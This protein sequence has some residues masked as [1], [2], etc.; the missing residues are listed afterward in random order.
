MDRRDFLKKSGAVVAGG[1]LADLGIFEQAAGEAR[2]PKGRPNIV[3]ILVDEM[4]FPRVFPAGVDT[5]AEFLRRY[6][7]N[8]FYLWQHGG[9]VRG[10]LQFRQR[11]QPGAS[12]DRDRPVP[13]QQ[14]L[15]ATR[16][17]SGPSL[18]PGLPT[19]GKLLRDSSATRP[20]I[21]ASGTSPIHRPMA[22]PSATWRTTASEDMKP[23]PVGTN[24]QGAQDDVSVIADSAAEWLR[25]EAR[26][27]T[28][29]CVTVSFVNPHDKQ[30]FWAGSE[31]VLREPVQKPGAEA[32]HPELHLGCER[33]EPAAVGIPKHPAE[34]GGVRG[35]AGGR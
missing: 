13:H 9:E 22:A 15:L 7:P 16:T 29:F 28:P 1:L 11:P 12:D 25:T 8:V 35:P 24:G 6:M 17:T 33:R 10:L 27:A 19:Y 32:L 23:D 4:R 34:L 31:N 14:W 5:P 20:R 26:S 21:S 3:F 2:R 18:Q 30:F